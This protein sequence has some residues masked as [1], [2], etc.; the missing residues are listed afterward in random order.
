MPPG[1]ASGINFMT[2]QLLRVYRE[3]SLEEVKAHLLIYG[4]LSGICAACQAMDVDLSANLCPKC[5][6]EFKF[7]AFRNV[8]HHLPKLQKLQA[9]RPSL[10]VIDFEDYQKNMGA[11]K[12]R[13]FFKE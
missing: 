11:S 4:D 8:R 1:G 9:Q 10:A 3:F 13:E 6:T 2:K 12:A 5:K 7:V